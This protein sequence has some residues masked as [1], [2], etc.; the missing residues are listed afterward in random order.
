MK[1]WKKIFHENGNKK[2]SGVAIL[3]SDKTDI[4]VKATTR[5]RQGHYIM[6]KRSLQEQDITIIIIRP[7]YIRQTL[8]SIKEEIDSNTI[9]MRLQYPTYTNGQ[10]I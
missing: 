6:I 3:M 1:G 2:K 10:I 9:I 8:T 4:K 7:Q 5:D